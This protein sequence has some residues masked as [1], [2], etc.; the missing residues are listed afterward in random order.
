MQLKAKK[1]NQL[2]LLLSSV[3]PNS[4]SINPASKKTQH[5]HLLLGCQ[6]VVH[7]ARSPTRSKR[8]H[9]GKH[10]LESPKSLIQPLVCVC[11]TESPCDPW[12]FAACR[13]SSDK[14]AGQNERE[15]GV[16][17]RAAERAPSWATNCFPL[18][19]Y[20]ALTWLR[21]YINYQTPRWNIS[22]TAV[23]SLVLL[24]NECCV[25]STSWESSR[26]YRQGRYYKSAAHPQE[27]SSC[28]QVPV[29]SQ[30]ARERK[31]TK[32]CKEGVWHSSPIS[33]F[34]R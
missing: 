19:V 7:P 29:A 10:S 25:Y 9:S 4:S 24:P 14:S 12:K 18:L 21:P 22:A 34:Q 33:H 6:Y 3:S 16:L 31:L 11:V 23:P 8:S 15:I 2:I 32:V 30:V 28:W 5:T 17:T 26:Q 13:L 27:L 1:C 20:T